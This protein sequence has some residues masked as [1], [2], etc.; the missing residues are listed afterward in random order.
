MPRVKVVPRGAGKGTLFG[1]N[2]SKRKQINSVLR[3]IKDEE[4]RYAG[5]Q[6]DLHSLRR[7]QFGNHNSMG[8]SRTKA[9]VGAIIRARE[10]KDKRLLR[11]ISD[12]LRAR[13]SDAS[14]AR[15]NAAMEYYALKQ[16]FKRV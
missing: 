1:R 7:D 6:M 2:W 4:G 15:D 5:L 16:R 13:R 8:D 3:A 9:K 11:E 14:A 10:D 12:N